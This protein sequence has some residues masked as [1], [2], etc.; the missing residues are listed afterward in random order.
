MGNFYLVCGISGGGKT[1]LSKKIIERNPEIDIRLDVD[2]YYAKINGDERIRDNTFQ[3]WHSL[4]QDLHNYEVANKN[5]IMTTNALTASQRNQ[6]I[7]W[8]P[9]YKHH[10]FWVTSPLEKCL[11]GNRNR[12]RNIPDDVLLHHWEIM[13]F[14]N[15]NEQGWDTIAHVTNCWDDENYIVFKLKGDAQIIINAE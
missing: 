1:T 8:F 9:S 5:V 15:A 3:V 11:E 2:E 13:E 14:P 10:M 12:Y 6:F 4:Y 7:E